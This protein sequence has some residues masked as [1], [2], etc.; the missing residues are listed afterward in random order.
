MTFGDAPTENAEVTDSQLTA[1]K[2]LVDAGLPPYADFSVWGPFG[3][4]HERRMKFKARLLDNQG[5]WIQV[6]I[7][8][9]SSIEAW[10]R[11]FKVF[12]VAAVMCCIASPATLQR[13]ESRFEERCERYHRAWHLCLQA[14]VRCRSEWL[15]AERRRQETFHAKHPTVSGYQEHKPWET[16]LREAADA[17]SSWQHELMEPAILFD[18]SRGSNPIPAHQ[19]L[20]EAPH[21]ED[22]GGGKAGWRKKRGPRGGS[23]GGG[24]PK[25]FC[26]N[27]NRNPAGCTEPCPNE[28]RHDCE[29][30]GATGVRSVN[31][32]CAK[33]PPNKKGKGKGTGK[34]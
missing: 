24:K 6:E 7:P 20:E 30:C 12:S 28:R 16:V 10:R 13:Y 2:Y 9:P 4:R 21:D 26:R 34:K 27:F 11:S 15:V 33:P 14:D 8:G 29:H 3:A 25:E 32:S 22:A 1:L 5:H 19:V 17:A 23:K 18:R 31:C